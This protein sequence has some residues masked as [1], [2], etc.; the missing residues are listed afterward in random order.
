M[1]M[2][3]FGID[4]ISRK[5]TGISSLVENLSDHL[6]KRGHTSYI[7]AEEDQYSMADMKNFKSSNLLLLKRG[8][9]PLAPLFHFKQYLSFYLKSNADIAHIHSLWS[10][11]TIAIYFWSRI[12]KR[13][14]IISTNGMLN[15]WAL[16][17]SRLKKQVFLGLIFKRII[18]GADSIILNSKAEKFYLEDKGWH[19]TFHIISNGVTMPAFSKEGI[20]DNVKRKKTLLF[21]SRIH[22]QKGIDILLDAWSDLYL[23]IEN[24][25][26]QLHVVGFFDKEHN[27]YEKYISDKIKLSPALSN[28]SISEGKFGRQMWD[29]YRLSD[30]FI[31]PTFSEGS[32]MVVL[33][34]WS[35]GKICLTTLGSNLEMGLDQECT[36]LIKPIVESIKEGILKLLSLTDQQLRVYG[37][38]GKMLV[39]DNYTWDK[40]VDKHVEIYQNAID[41]CMNSKG[42]NLNG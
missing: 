11:S 35:A 4:S 13:P 37:Q 34:A 16:N 9:N 33:N 26:W 1:M 32:A 24:K 31:L 3:I 7:V 23:D 5:N 15:Q 21:L 38:T 2:I 20:D 29:E 41:N 10:L 6:V 39:E 25:G 12:K 30:A 19:E 42:N 14:Y 22:E 8:S 40:I 27:E 28:V 18:R 17:Q 36:I